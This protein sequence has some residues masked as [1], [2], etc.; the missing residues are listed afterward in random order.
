MIVG[1]CC[2]CRYKRGRCVEW[3]EACDGY[4]EDYS[5]FWT[6][7]ADEIYMIDRWCG[8]CMVEDGNYCSC[9][10][11][12]DMVKHPWF[13]RA[14]TLMEFRNHSLQYRSLVPR[15]INFDAYATPEKK[16]IKK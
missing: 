1:Y 6:F 3:C 11:V 2:G 8:N 4:C 13:S 9:Y 12:K 15:R 10:R 7:W 5:W 14:M 16:K